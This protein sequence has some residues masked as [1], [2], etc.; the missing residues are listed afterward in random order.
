MSSTTQ[1]GGKSD[2]KS[3]GGTKKSALSPR[4]KMILTAVGVVIFAAVGIALMLQFA[5]SERDREMRQWQSRMSIVIDSRYTDIDRWLT[6]QIDDLRGIAD[7]ASVQLYLTVFHEAGTDPNAEDAPA[8]LGYLGNL[9]EVVADRAG[10]K[11]ETTGPQV[12][13]NVQKVG[14]AGLAL[15]DMDHFVI[16]SSSGFP[17]LQ[18]KL[19][20]FLDQAERGVTSISD[21]FLNESGQPSMAFVVPVYAVQADETPD[22]QL[23][24]VVGVK[25]VAGELFPLLEQPG[26]TEQTAETMIVRQSGNTIDYLTPR[27]D[28]TGPLKKGLAADTPNLASAWAVRTVGGF[29]TVTDYAGNEVLAISRAFGQVPWTL[30]YKVDTSEALAESEQRL[31]LLMVVFGVIIVLVLI[32]ML[33]LWYYGTSQRATEAANKFE[34]LANRFQGQRNFMHLVTD[35]QPNS[36]VILDEDGHYRWFNKT[37][38]DLSRMDRKD[39][40]DKHVSAILGPIEGKR[41]AA[42]VKEA[43]AKGERLTVTHEMELGNDGPKVYRSDFQPLPAREDFP[44]GV[45]MVSQDITES[46][47]EREKREAAMRQLV[48]TLVSVVDRRDPYSANHS[49][50]VGEVARAV[51]QEMQVERVL[52]ETAAIAGSL[53]NLGK[54][55]I[56]E[57]VLTKQG[58]LTPDEM[59]LIQQSVLTSADLVKD[60]DFD[61]PVY[62]T[63]RQL[64]EHFDGSGTPDHLSGKDIVVTARIGAVANAFV[65]MVSARAWRA[66]MSFDKALD[67]LLGD[68]NKKYDRGVVVALANYLDNRGGRDQWMSFGEPPED[69]GDAQA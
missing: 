11:S 57:E 8:E 15:V 50:R 14:V 56:P 13:A 19:R 28:G 44:P 62:D 7:N 41:I 48:G 9:L 24:Y 23:G 69:G 53:M 37:A 16:V 52:V 33:A 20:A 51:A 3:D 61:G 25:E 38:L 35:S 12:S 68:G 36:I 29:A 26:A 46:V 27:R 64:Q 5:A 42:W 32:G 17:P 34:E 2:G 59:Q 66:G 10:F 6:R 60:V 21:I 22:S 30:V 47:L 63:L 31:Q 4:L 49:V 45:L 1:D 40:F 65:G 55:T 39:M 67:I 18:G 54:I 43:L 58:A